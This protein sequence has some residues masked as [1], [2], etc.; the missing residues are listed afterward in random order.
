MEFSKLHKLVK[1]REYRSIYFQYLKAK[2]V[3]FI[4]KPI[5]CIEATY[6]AIKFER[7]SPSSWERY[8]KLKEIEHEAKVIEE[9][10]V[11][12][13]QFVGTISMF[14]ISLIS[15]CSYLERNDLSHE[16][17]QKLHE[18]FDSFKEKATGYLSK[19][20]EMSVTIPDELK[21][22]IKETNFDS[23]KDLH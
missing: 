15:Y 19:L 1:V 11:T 12:Y 3:N 2:I 14:N 8:L 22:L 13:V 10:S 23:F 4:K 17:F 16:K 20:E 5:V 7:T 21:E 9:K 18:E 6:N